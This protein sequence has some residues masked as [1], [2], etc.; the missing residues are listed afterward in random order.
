MFFWI[1]INPKRVHAIIQKLVDKN[2]SKTNLSIKLKKNN[3]WR[4]FI[5]PSKGDSPYSPFHSPFSKGEWVSQNKIHPSK[6]VNAF[7]LE[8]DS[9]SKRVNQPSEGWIV[10]KGELIKGE[11]RVNHPYEGWIEKGWMG[12]MWIHKS[13]IPLIYRFP[14][15]N[16][17]KFTNNLKGTF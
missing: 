8:G 4:T 1:I 16:P 11:W 7:T 3:I 13:R 17:I 10:E 5:H 12:I 6:R 14:L 2:R 9:P 15:D